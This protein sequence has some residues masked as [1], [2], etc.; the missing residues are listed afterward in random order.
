MDEVV[1]EIRVWAVG[2]ILWAH[3]YPLALIQLFHVL[4]YLQEEYTGK[5]V[6]LQTVFM[7]VLHPNQR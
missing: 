6:G 3:A 4:H 5:R 2:I 7:G 1:G